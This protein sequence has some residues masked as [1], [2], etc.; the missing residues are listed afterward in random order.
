[1]KKARVTCNIN[2]QL[3]GGV[4]LFTSLLALC[5][6][7]NYML[8][9]VLHS[10]RCIHSLCTSHFVTCD[11]SHDILVLFG[12]GARNKVICCNAF[13]CS[14]HHMLLGNATIALGVMGFAPLECDLSVLIK[15]QAASPP[16]SHRLGTQAHSDSQ[17]EQLQRAGHEP[18]CLVPGSVDNYL[19]VPDCT[20]QKSLDTHSEGFLLCC[21]RYTTDTT[22]IS[23]L[24]ALCLRSWP[25]NWTVSL[26]LT[27]SSRR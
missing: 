21:Y 5:Q 1:M 27:V 19:P 17:T 14:C 3:A 24:H 13:M 26:D 4:C 12:Q 23:A 11:V 16:C 9:V 22:S 8:R 7:F 20:L 15:M 6:L 18:V 10:L 25:T 2:Q